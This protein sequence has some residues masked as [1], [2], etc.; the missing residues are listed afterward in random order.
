MTITTPE[1][2]LLLIAVAGPLKV[3]IVC[4]SLTA[5]AGPEFIN[6]VAWKAVANSASVF[7]L[8]ILLGG[9]LLH[10]FHVSVPAFQVGGGIIL[11]IFA[12][13]TIT[14]EPHDPESDG[15][16]NRHTDPSLS[17]AAYPLAIPLIASPAA[18]VAVTAIIAESKDMTP[19]LGMVGVI[20]IIHLVDWIA[21]RSCR[22]IVS[23]LNPDILMVAAKV[24]SV[25]LAGLA[26]ELILT[27]IT[28][29]GPIAAAL[30]AAR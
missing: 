12:V 6:K 26:V 30:K 8:F 29:F 15:S 2:F 22:H 27:G 19:I 4:A 13:E 14:A 23:I 20:V 10:V 7:V 9:M 25:L 5:T 1:L 28:D 3:T 16:A 18:L 17:I 24:L 21:L 11:I